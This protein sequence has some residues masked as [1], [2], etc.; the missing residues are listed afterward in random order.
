MSKTVIRMPCSTT[1]QGPECVEVQRAAIDAAEMV[2]TLVAL[3][4]GL[5]KA[6]RW[7]R[8]APVTLSDVLSGKASR[9]RVNRLRRGLGFETVS[10]AKPEMLAW[11]IRNRVKIMTDQQRGADLYTAGLPST[12]CIN[13]EEVR[14]WLQAANDAWWQQTAQ[15][16]LRSLLA[17]VESDVEQSEMAHTG[18][19]MLCTGH[20]E[21]V[22]RRI[23]LFA[24]A[25][26]D[27]YLAEARAN[28]TQPACTTTE[29][30]G[31]YEYEHRFMW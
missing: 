20:V 7:M 2:R 10:S 21:P 11:Q 27:E 15:A 16:T 1:L 5:R 24:E 30:I 12:A 9:K 31:R 29:D 14:G 26:F 3:R 22:T 4:G 17:Q 19:R 28:P 23:V 13:L 8:I 18:K 25:E 6:A